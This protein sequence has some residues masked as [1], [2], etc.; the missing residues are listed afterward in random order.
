MEGGA[1]SNFYTFLGFFFV[2]VIIA[3]FIAPIINETLIAYALNQYACQFT[4][5]FSFDIVTGLQVVTTPLC[6]LDVE[7][8]LF[9]AAVGPAGNI[10]ISIAFFLGSIIAKLKKKYKHSLTLTIVFLGFFS[11]PVFLM[12][13]GGGE[14]YEFFRLGGMESALWQIPILGSVLLA[15]A[16]VYFWSQIRSFLS[17]K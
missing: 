15:L 1:K 3:L 5:Q 9:L 7:Q 13:S 17:E 8:R 6:E 2:F 16:V 12:L 11:F 10:I 14:L 4:Q